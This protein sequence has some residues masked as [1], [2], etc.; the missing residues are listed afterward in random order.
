MATDR[1]IGDVVLDVRNISLSFGGVK[2]LTDISFDIAKG[3]IRAIIR[4]IAQV[5]PQARG[6]FQE[7]P[8]RHVLGAVMAEI[9]ADDIILLRPVTAKPFQQG[10]AL[11]AKVHHEIV[12]TVR[13]HQHHRKLAEF[14][15]GANL[16]G[17]LEAVWPDKRRKVLIKENVS[18]IIQAGEFLYVFTGSRHMGDEGAVYRI[19][20]FDNDPEVSKVTLL[21]GW[22]LPLQGSRDKDAF[23]IITNEDLLS[24]R[25]DRG[26]LNIIDHHSV[27]EDLRPNSA[28]KLGNRIL[29]GM[30]PGVAVVEFYNSYNLKSIKM[31]V[32][33][34]TEPGKSITPGPVE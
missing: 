23:I 4:H 17:E 1:K 33:K 9:A 32:P 22:P 11:A 29:V 13:R 18:S 10:I 3:E 24:L 26:W 15:V 27:W 19:S 16:G 2:A 8:H 5:A 20:N 31:F 21:P 34:E 30:S 12:V 28:V 14:L 7:L 6:Y 25:I